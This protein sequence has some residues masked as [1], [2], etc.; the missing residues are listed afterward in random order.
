MENTQQEQTPKFRGL[1]RNVNISVKALD[2]V[3]VVC[4]LVIVVLLAIE[5]QDPGFTV[6]FD[7][8]GGSDVLPQKQ[9]YGETLTLPEPPVREGYSFTGWYR[10]TACQLPWNLETDTIREEITLYA[11][12]EKIDFR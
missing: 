4:L 10:D 8:R 5:L 12:W 11:G 7:S 2:T 3:I 6:T 1:Y 9:M